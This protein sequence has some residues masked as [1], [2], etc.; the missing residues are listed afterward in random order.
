MTTQLPTASRMLQRMRRLGI[1]S[2]ISL[3][4]GLALMITVLGTL[5]GLAV[6]DHYERQAAREQ[7]EEHE[8]GAL[9]R[10]FQVALLQSRAHQ[11]SY[12]HFL[13]HSARAKALLQEVKALPVSEVEGLAEFLQNE[14]TIAA[15][16]QN[17]EQVLQRQDA[18]GANSA[19]AANT[20]PNAEL[21]RRYD[22][23]SDQLTLLARTA[24]E[25]EIQA[26]A[27]QA[28]VRALR[29]N[30]LVVSMLVSIA[31]AVLLAIY[32]SRSIARPLEA[33]TQAAKRVTQDSNFELQI[34]IVSEDEVGI[35]AATLNHL[36]Q[37]VN[38]LLVQ[39]DQTQSVLQAAKAEAEKASIAKSEFLAN[40]SHELRTPL[41]G[42]LGYVQILQRDA[43]LTAKQQ[44]GISIIQQCSNHLL[45][46]ITDILDL[47]KIEAQRME[48]QSTDF[49]LLHFLQS[50]VEIC[51]I[52]AEQKGI[53]FTYQPSAS[54]P[55]GVRTD[56][57]RLRQV[58]INLLG[59]AIKFTD[60][61]G[62]VFSVTLIE[63]E[64]EPGSES[65]VARPDYPSNHASKADFRSWR[66]RFQ[67]SD[68]GIGLSQEQIQKIFLPFEQVGRNKWKVEG[69]GLGLSI[70]QRILELMGST[71]QVESQLGQGSVFK[72]DLE[73][74]E[75]VD[76]I[77][78]GRVVA[79]DKVVG[80]KG[81]SQKILL[82]DDKWQNRSVLVDLLQDIGFNVTEA[83]NGQEALE[84]A[85]EINPDLIITDLVMPVM[86]GF[87]LV[88]QLR[89]SPTFKDVIIIITS[90]SAFDAERQESLDAGG[91]AFLA[92]P[93]QFEA[94]LQKLQEY[95]H[96]EWIYETAPI[97]KSPR[98]QDRPRESI[99]DGPVPAITYV[100][101]PT[102]DLEYLYDLAMKGNINGIVERAEQ[103]IQRD[104]VFLPFATEVQ[105]LA[106]TFQ[107]KKIRE[108]I[109]PYR[110]L[111]P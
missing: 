52:R 71:I 35:L 86:D 76:W 37:E 77:Q 106:E 75:A 30:A 96:L 17:A 109:K 45:N 105:T 8:T 63:P 15:Y 57:R 104:E 1:S 78:A 59:N 83:A 14:A 44:E 84:R 88:R 41:N 103:L 87:E 54:L 58:L 38:H 53:T 82:V 40:M 68:T 47:S 111:K 62:V 60:K 36:I 49:H 64:V 67:V 13:Q 94:V 42:I 56:E 95:L 101:P 74:P 66:I 26:D 91:N 5:L 98:S 20:L 110:E 48:L 19:Q 28:D 33:V 43:N 46:L 85:L 23:L 80:F 50:V 12:A 34:P 90:A 70:S 29:I 73:L 108:F 2:K 4:Y 9:L 51:A 97:S 107:I 32:T 102:T 10:E 79:Q 55:V 61:G 100:A 21:V 65:Q 27:E 7:H 6:G 11:Q 92:K 18:I 25:R 16:L 22:A 24:F 39:N 72:L 81:R 31:L 69:T 3:G 99:A 89:R 93:L